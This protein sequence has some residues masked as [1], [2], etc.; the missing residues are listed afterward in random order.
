ML[1][2][3]PQT[4]KKYDNYITIVLFSQQNLLYNMTQRFLP[5]DETN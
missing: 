1:P 3:L 5:N 4:R 2:I